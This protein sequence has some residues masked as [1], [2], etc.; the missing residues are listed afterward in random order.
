M[1]L[2]LSITIKYNFKSNF[3]QVHSYVCII[4]VVTTSMGKKADIL[5]QPWRNDFLKIYT[6]ST[7]NS[8][9][10]FL[11]ALGCILCFD[12]ICCFLES[13]HVLSWRNAYGSV[14]QAFLRWSWWLDGQVIYFVSLF[15]LL[16]GTHI[17]LTLLDHISK[18]FLLVLTQCPTT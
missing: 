16:P 10:R 11:V 9:R 14:G 2:P 8:L 6:F 17:A 12:F 7:K 1:S 4:L 13:C 5:A 15:S 18:C 3:D